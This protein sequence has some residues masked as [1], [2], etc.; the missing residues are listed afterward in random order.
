MK[1]KKA[2]PKEEISVAK[3]GARHPAT[4]PMPGRQGPRLKRNRG[5]GLVEGGKDLNLVSLRATF[6]NMLC[7]ESVIFKNRKKVSGN[8]LMH[9]RECRQREL[10]EDFTVSGKEMRGGTTTDWPLPKMGRPFVVKG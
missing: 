7:W 8:H 6:G 2:K 9:A 1:E 3:L 5:C 10:M 4:Q